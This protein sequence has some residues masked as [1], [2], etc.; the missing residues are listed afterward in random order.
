MAKTALLL[1]CVA[2]GL[3]AVGFMIGAYGMRGVVEY[4]DNRADGF[5]SDVAS[6]LTPDDQ[7]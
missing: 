1:G 7:D 5:E 4:Y 6:E 3:L 2:T